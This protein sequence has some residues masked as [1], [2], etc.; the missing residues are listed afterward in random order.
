MNNLIEH[1]PQGATRKQG[2]R[3]AKVVLRMIMI[4][5]NPCTPELAKLRPGSNP[6]PLNYDLI[7]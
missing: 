5:V 1:E 2:N 7:F 4:I 3:N 6:A